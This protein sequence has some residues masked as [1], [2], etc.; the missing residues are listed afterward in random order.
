R[1]CRGV[2]ARSVREPQMRRRSFLQAAIGVTAAPGLAWAASATS[3]TLSPPRVLIL[4]ELRGGNDGLNTAVPIDDSR[5]HQLRPRLAL[6]GDA[7]IPLVPGIA[8]HASLAPWLP[9]WTEGEMALL[10]GVGYPE[11]KL[12]HFRCIEIWDTASA[13]TEV[14]QSGWLTRAAANSL[15]FRAC[16]ADGVILGAADLGPLMGGA[17]AVALADVARFTA[18]S[19][20]ARTDE[21]P[22]RGS[23]AHVLRVEHDIVN[24][25]ADLTSSRSFSTD[26]PRGPVRQTGRPASM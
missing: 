8:L 2:L 3:T 17:R 25:A 6:H 11:P 9:L 4:I 23:L 7:V 12:S 24:A 10:Q 19:R 13:S 16:A 20:L 18:Q 5:Y 22:A 26:F 21:T 15:P 14:L 1:Q